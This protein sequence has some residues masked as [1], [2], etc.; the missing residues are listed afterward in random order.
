MYDSGSVGNELKGTS[1]LLDQEMRA[2]ER[3]KIKQKKEI[4]QVVGYELKLNH[5]REQN[6]KREALVKEKEQRQQRQILRLKQLQEEKKEKDI[7]M[8]NKR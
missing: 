2:I 1:T 5:I 4:E 3:F 8:R 6:V 7:E